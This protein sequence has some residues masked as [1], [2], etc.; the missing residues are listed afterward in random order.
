MT[1]KEKH[2]TI[3]SLRSAG[4]GWQFR[5]LTTPVFRVAAQMQAH[6]QHRKTE[7]LLESLPAEIRKDIGWPT[8]DATDTAVRSRH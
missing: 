4:S 2:M 6:W 5:N 1:A 8:G 7:K 3:P